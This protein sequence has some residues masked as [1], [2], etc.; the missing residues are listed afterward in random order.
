MFCPLTSA[1]FYLLPLLSLKRTNQKVD[2]QLSDVLDNSPTSEPT[3]AKK[4]RPLPPIWERGISLAALQ[5]FAAEM[6]SSDAVPT[7]SVVAALRQRLAK[8]GRRTALVGLLADCGLRTLVRQRP[9]LV[10]EW[11]IEYDDPSSLHHH[12]SEYPEVEVVVAATGQPNLFL[13][14]AWSGSFHDSIAACVAWCGQQ[15]PEPLNPAAVYVWMD[16]F[17]LDQWTEV[18]GAVGNVV[19]GNSSGN[20]NSSSSSGASA[21]AGTANGS[22]GG[23]G[24]STFHA[25]LANESS[26]VEGF[27]FAV[28]ACGSTVCVASPGFTC[29]TAL[30]RLWCCAEVY[31]SVCVGAQCY[32]S[33]PPDEQEAFDEVVYA[34]LPALLRRVVHGFDIRQAECTSGADKLL[35]LKWLKS[36][37]RSWGLE[38]AKD[39]LFVN[40]AIASSLRAFLVQSA[41]RVLADR[42]LGGAATTAAAATAGMENDALSS[43]SSLSASSAAM[44]AAAMGGSS[45]G[46]ETVKDLNIMR[47]YAML[48][49]EQGR[50]GVG[51]GRGWCFKLAV[52]WYL[53]VLRVQEQT[54]GP[55]HLQTS[56]TILALAA[57]FKLQGKRDDALIKYER[58][59]AALET[60]RPQCGA[61][62]RSLVAAARCDLAVVLRD[63]GRLEDAVGQF[64]QSRRDLGQPAAAAAASNPSESDAARRARYELLKAAAFVLGLEGRGGDEGLLFEGLCGM[65]AVRV[66]QGQHEA[67]LVLFEEALEEQESVLGDGHPA[68]LNT[69]QC[70]AALRRR[71]LVGL[72]D[73]MA[74]DQL[75]RTLH[76][77]EVVFG[78][79]HPHTVSVVLQLAAAHARMLPPQQAPHNAELKNDPGACVCVCAHLRPLPPLAALFSPPVFSHL[80]RIF[81]LRVRLQFYQH[82]V[83]VY[84]IV[85]ASLFSPSNIIIPRS[86]SRHG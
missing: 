24:S 48:L 19:V 28:R 55:L 86:R 11:G 78:R 79:H 14:H 38:P 62:G 10:D 40:R 54:V 32:F 47:G 76:V 63:V 34:E 12:P 82:A 25:R 18:T 68:T 27:V 39:L 31:T 59:V 52:I 84:L 29:P 9:R 71:L 16:A 65:A 77:Y 45:A 80:P 23:A 44:A 30:E 5:L 56:K 4:L 46:T 26:I 70:I 53:K 1:F 35:L 20:G 42:N 50:A 17:C 69:I 85:P 81:L 72:E 73:T 49:E 75:E 41:R 13:S 3:F 74:V 60:L 2:V 22:S 43:S 51:G 37:Q 58:A 66:L 64:K 33:L 6:V 7:S 21:L 67:S 36:G 57:L 8:S 83:N 61:L 15:Q